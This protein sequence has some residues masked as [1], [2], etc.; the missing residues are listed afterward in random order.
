MIDAI[1]ILKQIVAR[2]WQILCVAVHQRLAG[3][4]DEI[5]G[6]HLVVG[7]KQRTD[8]AQFG[9]AEIIAVPSRIERQ[10]QFLIGLAVVI[11]VRVALRLLA[12]IT[13]LIDGVG[14]Q[15]TRHV[16]TGL[17]LGC[18]P[19]VIQLRRTFRH[20]RG[21]LLRLVVVRHGKTVEKVTDNGQVT[22]VLHHLCHI[23]WRHHHVL[24]LM[25][26]A[27]LT[28]HVGRDNTVAIHIAVALLIVT[29]HQNGKVAVATIGGNGV[30]GHELGREMNHHRGCAVGNNAYAL[31][32][33]SPEGVVGINGCRRIQRI[34]G[35]RVNQAHT[36]LVL[37]D[38]TGLCGI[39]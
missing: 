28:G 11:E 24:H 23:A 36:G 12:Q 30:V 37:H 26:V 29:A 33:T 10:F 16:M 13:H 2:H 9:I 17:L 3:A 6:K 27:V 34:S 20:T 39:A 19:V 32:K 18:I 21:R 1:Q 7:D 31:G 14:I 35:D 5:I 22:G 25:D 38:T 8:I 4:V 15:D